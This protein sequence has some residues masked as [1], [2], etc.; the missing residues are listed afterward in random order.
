[1]HHWTHYCIFCGSKGALGSKCE[2]HDF[3][4]GQ[5]DLPPTWTMQCMGSWMGQKLAY[6]GWPRPEDPTAPY[7]PAPGEWRKTSWPA[8]EY[9]EFKMNNN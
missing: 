6:V 9:V 8:R 5:S 2:R 1:M 3:Y 4:R 7:V